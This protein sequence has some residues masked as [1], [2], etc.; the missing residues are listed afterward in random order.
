ME[1][2]SGEKYLTKMAEWYDEVFNERIGEWKEGE[3]G[4]SQEMAEWYNSI[5]IGDAPLDDLM[6]RKKKIIIVD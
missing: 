6:Y 3:I 2:Y 5:L 4:M 1:I